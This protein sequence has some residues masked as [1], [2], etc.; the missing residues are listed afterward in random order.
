[1]NTQAAPDFTLNDLNG[2]S[3]RLSDH[4]EKGFIVLFFY[5]KNET[6]GCTREACAF[7]DRFQD[8]QDL[9]ALVV[10]IS[11]DSEDSH[12]SF[13]ANHLLPYTLLS[14]PGKKVHQLYGV[15]GGLFG[16]LPGRVTFIID[17]G[18]RIVHRFDS[19]LRFEQH[20]LEAIETI[21]KGS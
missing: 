10:G 1:M 2:I 6:G 4:L 8:F 16:L 9:G 14:D 20:V 21:R 3:F 18:G 11:G 17:S 12:R 15:K 19:L 13:A 5:P 7:R